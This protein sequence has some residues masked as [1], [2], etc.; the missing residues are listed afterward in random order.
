VLFGQHPY[1]AYRTAET[2]QAITRDDLVA[3][4][5]RHFLPNNASLAIVGDV[6]MEAILPL[7]K[8]AL[9]GWVTGDIPKIDLPELPK[10][11]GVTVHL[12]DRPGS[13][14][15]NFIIQH[16]GPKRNTPD[17]PGLNVLNATLGG[18]FSGRLFQNLRERHGWTYGAYSV[19]DYMKLAGAFE[20]SAE[21]RNEV[22][23]P[24]VAETLKE[25]ARLRDE[26]VPEK[27]LELQRQY[28][29]GNYL[30]SLENAGRVA[31][32]VQDIDLYGLPPDFYKHYAKRMAAATPQ[33]TQELAQ[34]YLH[35]DRAEIIVV[36]EGKEI[37]PE[38]EKF[39]KVFVYDT[40]LKPV[41]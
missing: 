22:T 6:K 32:R 36:G 4:H 24:A 19:F 28:N 25:I 41:P 10:I 13:V 34:K 40:D 12:V 14:Q 20:A 11:D 16:A 8:K 23:A 3:F 33:S 17:L 27:E 21:T 29:V 15:S 26:A 9:G 39:G 5:K 35:P 30:L 7:L 37:K 18:G 31:Q 38:L 1:G 2:V